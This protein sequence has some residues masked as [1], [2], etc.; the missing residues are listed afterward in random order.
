MFPL[1]SSSL[2]KMT[3]RK[4]LYTIRS[5][6]AGRCL[7]ADKQYYAAAILLHLSRHSK[8]HLMPPRERHFFRLCFISP[9]WNT[10]ELLLEKGPPIRSLLP[11]LRPLHQRLHMLIAIRLIFQT[12]LLHIASVC[13]ELKRVLHA[14]VATCIRMESSA[15]STSTTAIIRTRH[16]SV[17]RTGRR[18]SWSLGCWLRRSATSTAT[19][20]SE[21]STTSSH[22]LRWWHVVV[23][24]LPRVAAL[25][26]AGLHT[27]VCLTFVLLLLE[28]ELL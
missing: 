23:H 4:L 21:P 12:H 20:A 26:R 25:E 22:A 28:H 24:S 5:T 1:L 15:S 9:R 2:V 6:R 11:E 14:L 8:W 3:R 19:S 16:A 17:S 7:I 27:R 13:S 10:E 18:T